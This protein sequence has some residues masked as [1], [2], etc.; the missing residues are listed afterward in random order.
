MR[1]L[2]AM[3]AAMA[4]WISPAA[5]QSCPDPAAALPAEFAGWMDPGAPAAAGE[6]NAPAAIE[7]G[8]SA[9]MGLAPITE[10]DYEVAPERPAPPASF[11]GI[12]SFEVAQAGTYRVGL[13]GPAWID[14][15]RDGALVA[16]IAHGRGPECSGIRKIVD[17]PLQ[18]GRYLLQVSG[19][20]EPRITAMVAAAPP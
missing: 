3:A 19:N 11:G 16:S 2:A 8:L 5:A 10:V 6:E 18:P 12:V 17:F 15:V 7:V 20:P 1:G 4:L 9:R 13:D 14:I